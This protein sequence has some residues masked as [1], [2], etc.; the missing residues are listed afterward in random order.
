MEREKTKSFAVSKRMV[1]NSYLK[2]VSKD[3]GAGI[4]NESID[5]FNANMSKNL[6]KIYNRMASG[7]YF[8]PPVRTVFI[9]KKQ[10]GF[11]PLG[12]PTVAD[13][14]A[15]GVVKD[16][17]EAETDKMFHNSSFGYR[18]GRSAHDALGQCH[19]NCLGYAWVI[20]VDIKGFFDNISH[21]KLMDLLKQHTQQKWV[22]LYVERWLKA[23][24]EQE[25]GTIEARTKGT[26]QGG[27]I[28]PLL[29]NL[30]LHYALDIWMDETN[31]N[32]PFERYA[33][34]I[35]IHCSTKEEAEKL[36]AALGNRMNEYSLTLH[37]EKTKVVYCKNHCRKE[38]H[39]HNSFTFLSY[40]FRPR[41]AMDK[42]DRS[43]LIVL[44][45]GAISNAAKKSIRQA[46]RKVLNPRWTN[47]TLEASANML[48][49]KIRGWINYYGK[50]FK[51]RMIRIFNYV[52]GLIRSWI[53]NKYKLTSKAKTLEEFKRIRKE[54]P[55]MFYHWKFGIKQD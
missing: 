9:P 15:Q 26:P 17:L 39:E 32:N 21:E 46:V 54:T 20:D 40:T 41:T 36:L 2:V 29:A 34:D 6:Y 47:V 28:S 53:T 44:F 30:Y 51:L 31:K 7:S 38:A 55:F 22:L 52:D 11:R 23:G 27:V 25:D 8:P 43:K 37:P 4:D 45:N 42:F 50:F 19:V 16:Y 33:D 10:G 5:M 35:V 18:P 1:Y 12:I 14:I 24:I 3:G 13:R 49:P 48:N